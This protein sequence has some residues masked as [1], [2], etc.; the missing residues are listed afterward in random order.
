MKMLKNKKTTTRK[1]QGKKKIARQRKESSA[2]ALI[3]SSPRS[4]TNKKL[5]RQDFVDTK[6][7]QLF[8]ELNPSAKQVDWNIEM[9]ADVREKIRYWLVEYYAITKEQNFY[10]Y[11]PE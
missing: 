4:L 5:E 1:S 8:S 6:I 11:I 9:I 2:S 3:K 7:F 10:P